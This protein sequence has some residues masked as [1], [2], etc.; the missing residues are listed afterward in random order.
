ME[1]EE[2]KEPCVLHFTRVRGK[3]E[4]DFFDPNTDL[5][6]V[7][8]AAVDIALRYLQD[9]FSQEDDLLK[10]FEYLFRCF[11]VFQ[12]RVAEDAANFSRQLQ[13]YTEAVR[14]ASPNAV[15]LW[16]ETLFRVLAAVYGLY[17]RRDAA[18]DGE[19]LRGMMESARLSLYRD[20]LPDTLYAKVQGELYDKHVALRDKAD[21]T[22]R[23]L[24]ICDE[25][26]EVIDSAKSVAAVFLNATGDT[27]WNALA[28]A[29]DREFSTRGGELDDKSA[30]CLALAY[31]SYKHND[32]RVTVERDE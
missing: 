5:R 19:A 9:V 26:E 3:G 29:C 14:K 12:I 30:T 13:E 15:W 10:D 27:D 11:K 4:T 16:R 32:L 8:P 23:S 6:K 18:A 25:T 21:T 22:T 31:P 20:V 17:C 2:K 1:N 28:D 7:F 24:I